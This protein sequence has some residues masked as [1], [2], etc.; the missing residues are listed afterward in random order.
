MFLSAP[1][2]E[3]IELSI[4]AAVREDR[5]PQAYLCANDW[6]ALHAMNALQ[7][8]GVKIPQ[9]VQVPGFDGLSAGAQS[10][11]TL[12]TARIEPNDLAMEL[13]HA[14]HSRMLDPKRSQRVIYVNTTVFWRGS[15]LA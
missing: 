11:P 9:Q 3:S 14:I 10:N 15:T 4:G 6:I 2:D 5:L 1:M 13:L 8:N 12:T 7:K